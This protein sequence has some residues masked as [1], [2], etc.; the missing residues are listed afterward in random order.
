M[1]I[2]T[3]SLTN[4]G[5]REYNDDTVSIR[6]KGDCTWA[7][8]GDGLGGYAGGRLASQAAGESLMDTAR[9]GSLL[10]DERLR[11]AAEAAHQ[12]GAQ[13]GNV[14]RGGQSDHGQYFVRGWLSPWTKRALQLCA[15]AALVKL[16]TPA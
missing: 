13:N 2:T 4:A 1:R 7:Y 11:E 3:A 6:Q 8:V 15:A 16:P 9:R 14:R 10:T 5:G 12:A